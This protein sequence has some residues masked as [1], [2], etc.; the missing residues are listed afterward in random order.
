M[1]GRFVRFSSVERFAD[2]FHAEGLLEA[3]ASYNIAPSTYVLVPELRPRVSGSWLCSSEGCFH[4]GRMNLR[5]NTAPSTPTPK[6]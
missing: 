3:K 5:P 4:L 2:L 1:C 6:P